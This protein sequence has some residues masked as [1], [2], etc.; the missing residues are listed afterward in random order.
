MQQY[1]QSTWHQYP[2]RQLP[3][4]LSA[5][6]STPGSGLLS[7][8][9]NHIRVT[10]TAQDTELTRYLNVA[11]AK[12]EAET[13]RRLINTSCTEYYDLWPF[14]YLNCWQL[15]LAPVS[16]IT[17]IKYYDTD[18]VQQTWDSGNY[19]TDLVG[20]PAR[21]LIDP[22]ATLVSPALDQRPNC[23]A[24]AY[25]AGYG[26]AASNLDASTINALFVYAAWL[27]GPGRELQAGQVPDD[28][29]NRCWQAEVRRLIW[30]AM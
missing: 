23:V 1:P 14:D 30:R 20:T 13:D 8:F 15:H 17:S 22:D 27:N 26:A 4:Q 16:A 12:L 18:A 3:H 7:D 9:K 6:H 19:Q 11:A 5:A 28:A 10:G 25:T 21:I 29:V 24:V 2:V